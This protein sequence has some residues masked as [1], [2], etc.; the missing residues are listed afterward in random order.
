MH[1]QCACIWPGLASFTQSALN[2]TA[3]G[4]QTD[5]EMMVNMYNK[6][7]AMERAGQT[8]D[9]RSIETDSCSSIPHCA[10]SIGSLS[11]FNQTHG[12]EPFGELA[13]YAKS[14]GT[15]KRGPVRTIGSDFFLQLNGLKFQAA[16]NTITL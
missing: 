16:P 2:T 11:S 3:Q 5:I 13:M 10:S 9:W 15:S 4:H 7:L 8:I 1:W 14:L 6:A 12:G